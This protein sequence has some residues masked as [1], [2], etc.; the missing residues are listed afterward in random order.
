MMCVFLIPSIAFMPAKFSMCFT[1][2]M[3]SL[4]AAMACY[5]GPRLYMK[6]LFIAKNLVASSLLIFSVLM[7]LWFSLIVQSYVWSLVWCF[8]ELNAIIFFFCNTSAISIG[9]IK[10]VCKSI[11]GIITGM[12]RNV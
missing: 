12:F 2:A 3:V 4:I 5:N 10:W 6:K 1:L 8:C 9:T 7:A 11:M